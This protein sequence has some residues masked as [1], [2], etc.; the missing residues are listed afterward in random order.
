MATTTTSI[1]INSPDLTGDVIAI[2]KVTTLSKAGVSTGLDQTTGVGRKVTTATAQY[3]LVTASEYGDNKAHK[4]YIRIPSNN[5]T[6][7]ATITIGSQSVGRLYGGD[8]LF[9]PYDGTADVKITP[10]VSTSF[11]VEHFLIFEV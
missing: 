7:F 10:S 4:L 3:T 6:E 1:S 9:M 11:A 5:V 8:F 2:N